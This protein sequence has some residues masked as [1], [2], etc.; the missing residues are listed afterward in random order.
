[1]CHK[2]CREQQTQLVLHSSNRPSHRRLRGCRRRTLCGTLD[3]LPPE[4]VEGRDHDRAVDIWSLG[5]L[6][7]EFLVG[8]PPFQGD[9]AL[10]SGEK[11]QLCA[12]AWGAWQSRAC[13][14][15]RR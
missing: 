7:Y 6:A 14:F 5:V 10:V 15:E 3:Y 4:M 2:V 1:M 8:E 13:R 11:G 12:R 9:G